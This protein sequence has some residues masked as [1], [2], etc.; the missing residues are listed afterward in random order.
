MPSFDIYTVDAFTATKFGGNAAGVVVIPPGEDVDA[1][2]K[3]AIASEFNLPMTA[4]IQLQNG[5]EYSLQW[6]NPVSPA[7]FCG[8]ATLAAAHVLLNE[9]Q[10]P[11]PLV[12]DSRVGMLCVSKQNDMITL[13]FPSNP[14]TLVANPPAAYLAVTNELQLTHR[15][16]FYHAPQLNDLVILID[17]ITDTE[18]ASME[19]APSQSTIDGILALNLRAI[20]FVARSHTEDADSVARV[21]NVLHDRVPEDQVTGSAHTIVAPLFHT[22]YGMSTIRAHQCS[23]RGGRMLLELNNDKVQVSGSAVTVLRGTI[24]I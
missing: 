21:F 6:F 20:V 22:L 24:T 11:L 14:P 19:F 18:L 16:A 12:F 23:R 4:F 7:A 15:A 1:A 8:H 5:S 13:E 9:R 17:G 2:T 3:Q 10:T